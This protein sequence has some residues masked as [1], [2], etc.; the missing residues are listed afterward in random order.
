MTTTQLY[1]PAIEAIC[2]AGRIYTRMSNSWEEDG[3]VYAAV[4]TELAD[5]DSLS[6]RLLKIGL[7]VHKIVSLDKGWYRYE[8]TVVKP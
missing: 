2:K 6:K 3:T 7:R 4:Y 1:Y 8:M 5:P